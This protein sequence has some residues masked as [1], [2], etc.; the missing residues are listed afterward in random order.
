MN[1]AHQSSMFRNSTVKFPVLAQVPSITVV[2]IKD[3]SEKV[4]LFRK[5]PTIIESGRFA[6]VYSGVKIGTNEQVAIKVLPRINL[7]TVAKKRNLEREIVYLFEMKG[8]P[9]IVQLLAVYSDTT[10]FYLIFERM[11]CDLWTYLNGPVEE[12]EA[13]KI[14]RL[15]ALG[16][17]D[18][19]AQDIVHRDVKL[20]NVLISG[21]NVKLCD[22][23]FAKK[24]GGKLLFRSCGS[25][26]TVPPEILS[27]RGYKSEVDLW[28]LGCI[29][30]SLLTYA[31]P[32]PG[33]TD[34]DIFCR[35][36]K[37][38]R[39]QL[40]DSTSPEAKDLLNGLLQYDP[41]KRLTAEQVLSHPWLN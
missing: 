9:Y 2:K 32:F 24:T 29:L 19:H 7:I 40:P 33:K 38:K 17:R 1:S 12:D 18:L 21:E 16:L 30:F 6:K 36:L 14:L 15:I 23:G 35:I 34:N 11:K 5:D 10:N 28:G 4:G 39:C 27:H 8:N 37:G 3:G 26:P 22:F 25:P 31:Y 41:S 13:K 20:E